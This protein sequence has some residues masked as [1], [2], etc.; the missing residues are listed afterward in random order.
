MKALK[1]SRLGRQLALVPFLLI[2]ILPIYILVISA[3]KTQA[4]IV[5]SPLLLPL[6]RL[7][8]DNIV[9]A[10]TSPELD[11][12]G[13]LLRTIG[14]TLASVG[15][16]TAIAGMVSYVLSRS[17]RRWSVIVY[18][19]LI[20]G[21]LIPSQVLL[22]PVIRMFQF[23]HINGTFLALILYMAATQLPYAIFLYMGFISSVPRELDEAAFVDGAGV[24]TTFWRIIFPVL[25]PATAA[26]AIFSGLG[27]FNN[28]IDPLIIL[29]PTGGKTITTGIYSAV[30][31]YNTD[32]ANVFGNLFVAVLPIMIVYAFMQRQFIDGLTEG[33][34]KG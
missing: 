15:L 4:D 23:T 33:S 20:M 30:G 12:V 29:G 21:I 25:R 6:D 32:Y 3:F 11:I 1:S 14:I 2:S 31:Q 34:V 19:F 13:S 9:G 24:F 22:I 27:A 10:V 26:I 8:L 17:R 28:F 16:S 7:T 18:V 5:G